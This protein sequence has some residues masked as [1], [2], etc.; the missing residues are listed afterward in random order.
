[1][2][3]TQYL[4]KEIFRVVAKAAEA[5]G[6]DVYVVGGYVRDLVL[7]RPSKDIDF[8]CV[9]SGIALAKKVAALLGPGIQ[10]N[11][12]G[13]FG[14]AQIRYGD[15]DIEFVGARKES[16]SRDSRK[17]IVEDGTLED[18]L[19]RRDF[20]INCMAISLNRD[21]YGALIDPH[22]GMSDLRKKII[23]TPQDPSVTFSDDPLRM[24]RAV[25][26]ATQ[27]N[28]DIEPD[29]YEAI[30]QQA[31]RLKIVSQERITDELNKIIA[32]PVPSYGFKLLFH[33][34]LLKQ[35]FPE[36][37]ALHGVEYVGNNAHKDNFFHTLQVLDNVAKV[38]DDL[39][40]RWAAILHDIAK[41]ATKRYDKEHGWTF[42]G[43]E[44]K[45]AR[46]VPGIFRRL[47]LPMN[48]NMTRVQKLVRLHLR[49]IPLAREVT[50]SAIR[51]LLFDAGDDIDALMILCRADVTSKNPEKV[52]RFLRNFDLV[53]KKMAEVEQKDHIRNFQP[54]VSGDEIMEMFDI[55]PSRMVGELKEEIKEAILDGRIANDRAQAIDFLKEIAA[56][57]GLKSRS[58]G[59]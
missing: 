53:E 26:F 28:F 32:S 44:D 34:G 17:P 42:H 50:D 3:F 38:S 56:A 37:V 58:T 51:R 6:V 43:H 52:N 4:D 45:G 30:V 21:N 59:T 15:L 57:R 20:T 12:F 16:Y 35:F 2:D 5:S 14:T 40:L 9:G 25:R 31:P 48:E 27:L 47:K 24:M 18:D 33:S 54:P 22:D 23:R 1:M 39:W 36:L 19:K 29:T 13:N 41:P 10:A 8:V 55:P 49:P 7:G 46:M 11:Y